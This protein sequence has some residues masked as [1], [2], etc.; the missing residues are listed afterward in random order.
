MNGACVPFRPLLAS[1]FVLIAPVAAQLPTW[2]VHAGHGAWNSANAIDIV[3]LG[4]GYYAT[5]Q[6]QFYNPAGGG[7]GDVKK[8]VD[9]LLSIEP[10]KAYKEFL[11]IHAVFRASPPGSQI[12]N[13]RPGN[14]IRATSAYRCI[15]T[16]NNA[17]SSSAIIS[18]PTLAQADA[19][20]AP[21][22]GPR[23]TSR[24][25]RRRGV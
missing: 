18:H 3:I 15:L 4:D 24:R 10:Y 8:M 19:M 11:K 12:G 14:N 9:T 6:N 5:Q 17:S 23:Q 20:S 2:T 1:A 21:G 22:Y 13:T 16:G 7:S 25:R